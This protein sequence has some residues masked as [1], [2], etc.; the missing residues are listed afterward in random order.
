MEKEIK[1]KTNPFFK[2]LLFDEKRY[3]ILYGGAGSGKSYFIAQKILIRC[4]QN[5]ERILC[6]RK[7]AESI[8]NS[9]FKL[10]FDIITANELTGIIKINKSDYSFTF[11][12]GSQILTTGLDDV[13]KLKSIHAISSIWIEEATEVMESDFTQLDLRLRGESASYKQIIL[14]FNPIDETHWLK[15]RFF[16][17]K[18]ESCTVNHSTFLNNQFIDEEYKKMLN[19]QIGW[20]VNMLRIYING[21]WGRIQTGG[22]FYSHFAFKKHVTDECNYINNIPI[23]VSFDQNVSPYITA[24]LFQI[25]GKNQNQYIVNCID[26]FCLSN[27]FNNTESLCRKIIE[28]Y[29]ERL[30]G[31]FYYGDASGRKR[32]TRSRENDYEIIERMFKKYIRNYSNRV[33]YSNPPLSK[34]RDFI[35]KIL[36]TEYPIKIQIN[37]QCK[38]MIADLECVKEDADG[39]KLKQLYRNKETGQSY[40]KYGHCS[41]AMD[42]FLCESFSNY[43][44]N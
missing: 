12:N 23:H 37:S 5:K 33:P 24:V 36:E 18:P 2:K 35:N 15:H 22:E 4:L 19:E 20:D 21:E 26:E 25:V 10:F 1:I 3:L 39:T 16:D 27:P 40:E 28:K 44:K 7:T 14:S 41:D 34:R 9:I 30:N 29:N 6:C 32:D 42:Y 43:F 31:L 38:K 11:T 8:K 17:N 13:E